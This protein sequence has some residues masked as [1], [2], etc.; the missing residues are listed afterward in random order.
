MSDGRK[1]ERPVLAVTLHSSQFPGGEIV[2]KGADPVHVDEV[3]TAICGGKHDFKANEPRVIFLETLRKAAES[4]GKYIRQTGGS[5]NY[6]HVKLRLEP[7]GEGEGFSFVNEVPF[8]LLPEV[9]AAAAEAGVHEAALGGV[10]FGYEVTAVKATLIDGSFHEADSNPMA[11]QIAGA[12]AFKEAAK[13]ASPVLLEPVMSVL[14]VLAE[15]RARS[16]LEDIN[17]RRGRIEAVERRDGSA[18]F[19]AL[20]PL[21]ET[22]RSSAHGRLE[23]AMQ[24]ARY[25]PVLNPHGEFGGDVLGVGVRNPRRPHLNSGRAEAELYFELE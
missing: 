16:F 14:A 7:L 6:G 17:A 9:Y 18:A 22:L 25:E 8:A 2:V 10:L 24:F 21:R 15:E 23:Y 13:K 12:M 3:C 1:H 20:A 5:G 11:F 4:E 19:K